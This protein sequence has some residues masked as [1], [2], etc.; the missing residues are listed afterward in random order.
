MPNVHTGLRARDF[1]AA[2]WVVGLVRHTYL[3]LVRAKSLVQIRGWICRSIVGPSLQ[4]HRHCEGTRVTGARM[5][6][7]VLSRD[8]LALRDQEVPAGFLAAQHDH[9]H[10]EL[11]C[12]ERGVVLGVLVEV[13][14]HLHAG[15][16]RTGELVLL[17]V[18]LPVGLGDGFRA[19]GGEVVPEVLEV[20]ALAALD[21]GQRRLAV[22]VEVPEVLQQE[23]VRR[24]AHT[25]NEGVQQR[26][27]IDLG[28]ILGGIRVGYH[29]ADVVT[30]HA[31]L[32]DAE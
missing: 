3:F 19:V 12:L 4:D 18:E 17:R 7:A 26:D 25:R 20:D 32:P 8:H 21:E 22:E 29:Q 2:R 5:R 16:H 10:R 1:Q 30:G 14:E 11:R 24:I 28:R 6:H 15:L 31:S 9:R 13:T 23:E 27:A